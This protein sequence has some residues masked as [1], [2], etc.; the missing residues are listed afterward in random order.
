MLDIKS[1]IADRVSLMESSEIREI[2][3][4]TEG[5]NV[6]SL[7]G[8]LPDPKYFPTEELA[9]ISAYVIKEYGA[10]ALQY[11]I[12]R[13]LREFR[14]EIA[15]FMERTGT[16]GEMP[17][18]I[19]V[20]SGSQQALNL[21]A[22]VLVNPGD[23][24]VVEKPTYLAAINEFKSVGALFEGIPIDDDGMRTDIL[25][26][27]LKALKAEGKKVKVVYTVPTAQN[28][29]GVS[30]SNE[31]RSHLLELAEEYDF[32]I[33]EDDPYSHF[34]FEDVDFKRLRSMDKYR[35][36]YTSTFSKILAPGLRLG[37]VAAHPEVIDALEIAKQNADLHTPTFNQLIATEALKRGVVDRHIPKV[38]EAYKKKR[39][40]ML[41]ALEEYMDGAAKWTKPVGGLF[42]FVYLDENIDTKEMLPAALSAGVAYVPG[43]AFY[44]DGSGR[45]T[46][47]LNFSYPDEEEIRVGIERLSQVVKSYVRGS[48]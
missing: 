1:F 48:V 33:I 8:G 46:M 34:M 35:V 6:I 11:S 9:E 7:A 47:R 2:L 5:K 14:K 20:T 31:R 15:A 23:I 10:R 41:N 19:I 30:M 22:Q 37:W 16:P 32:L 38:K 17:Y 40:A 26:E 36:I 12:T 24:V 13:G 25:E 18:N 28:P 43:S 42:V 39:D 45:N 21:L 29:S 4:L 44:V 3:E 27:R